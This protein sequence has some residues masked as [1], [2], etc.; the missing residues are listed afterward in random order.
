MKV[1]HTLLLFGLMID[2][3]FGQ[4]T[5][6]QKVSDFEQI[7]GLYAKRYAPYEWKRDTLGFDLLN[8]GPWIDKILA[9]KDDL[10]FYEVLSEYV[11]KLNDAHDVYALPANFQAT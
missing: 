2:V 6:E 5:V 8:A 1:I 10:D 11:S 7:A 4:L 9:T 3:A